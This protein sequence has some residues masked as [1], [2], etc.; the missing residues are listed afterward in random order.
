[1]SVI[2]DSIRT[3]FRSLFS[4]RLDHGGY[5]RTLTSI[6][7]SF[8]FND[9]II[10]PDEPTR[11]LFVDY[12]FGFICSNNTAICYVR[13][14][15]SKPFLPLPDTTRIRFL[16]RARSAFLRKTVIEPAGSL[17]VY[18]FTNLARTG[19]G[20]DKYLTKNLG[21]VSADDLFAVSVVEPSTPCLAV[22][23]IFTKDVGNDYRL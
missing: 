12:G 23:D 5:E 14:T 15:G 22:I 3:T 21:G 9:L 17:Q 13:S 18:Q 2:V 20:A 4:I 1:M 8:I 10:E 7:S 6:V 19:G 11:E 16:V